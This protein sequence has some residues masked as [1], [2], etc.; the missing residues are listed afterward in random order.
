MGNLFSTDLRTTQITDLT[1]LNRNTINQYLKLFRE[2]LIE[3]YEKNSPISGEV[4]VD[5]SYFGTS[6]ISVKRTIGAI[7]FGLLKREGKVYTE[8][9]TKK[10]YTISNYKG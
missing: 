9:S 5:E 2:H 10:R 8:N 6:K 3:I 4:E 1:N 7:V